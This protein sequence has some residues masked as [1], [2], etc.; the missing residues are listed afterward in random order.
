[1]AVMGYGGSDPQGFVAIQSCADTTNTGT[2][3]C[4]LGTSVATSSPDTGSAGL[5]IL[6]VF[7][8]PSA[9]P[10][11]ANPMT[12]AE[13]RGKPT[14]AVGDA[15]ADVVVTWSMSTSDGKIKFPDVLLSR[16]TPTP[17]TEG[18]VWR[19]SDY[20]NYGRTV[21]PYDQLPARD[22]NGYLSGSWFLSIY[23]YCSFTT[24]ADRG[25]SKQF[26][27]DDYAGYS[28]PCIQ[29]DAPA[30]V[31]LSVSFIPRKSFLAF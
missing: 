17:K 26:V 4:V 3:Q 11:F 15:C 27:N 25:K 12:M 21:I 13:M 1:M 10:D 28:G 8:D 22:V 19:R 16:T 31:T 6:G 20:N 2:F 7:L 9:A 24:A 14:N 5:F 30:I 23:G 18:Y 29:N